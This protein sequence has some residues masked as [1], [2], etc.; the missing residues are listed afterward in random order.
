MQR[1]EFNK[2]LCDFI[3]HGTTPFHAAQA[4]HD[5]L[6]SA[7]FI[8]LAEAQSW[9]LEPGGRYVLLRNGSSLI[10]FTMGEGGGVHG[11]M[12]RIA[13]V[14]PAFH[15]V[16]Q[17]GLPPALLFLQMIQAGIADNPV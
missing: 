3:A 12:S 8:S 11:G 9:S 2:G 5:T 7:G 17:R 4:M 10:A 6:L 15:H 16:I 13:G 14:E 1:E